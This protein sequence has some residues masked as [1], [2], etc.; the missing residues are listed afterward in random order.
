M[1]LPNIAEDEDSQDHS[2]SA[3]RNVKYALVIE[4]NTL[5]SV[6]WIA[7]GNLLY[8]AGSSDWC[9]VIT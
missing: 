8:D 4:T 1:I 5:P 2:Y 9:S 3:G 7:S 6:K